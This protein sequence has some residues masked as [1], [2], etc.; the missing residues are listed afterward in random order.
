MNELVAKCFDVENPYFKKMIEIVKDNQQ[1]EKVVT[2]GRELHHFIPRAYYKKMNLSIDN[3]PENLVSLSPKDH[4]KIHYFIIFCCKPVIKNSMLY[5]FRNMYK[6]GRRG[7][8]E[9]ELDYFADAYERA[10][11][12]IIVSK[13]TRQ[14]LSIAKKGKKLS[15]ETRKKM[16]IAMTGKKHSEE[17]RKKIICVET[18]IVY[19]SLSEAAEKLNLNIGNL[20][21]CLHGRR[22][23]T[24][25]YHFH[26]A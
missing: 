17:A 8:T 15:E 9:K 24:G 22:K 14:K 3:S 26:L 18:G 7:M 16:S 11:S 10:K 5:A 20:S 12:M 23:T 4:F 21:A 1:H 25:G 2:T 13:A 6:M 19:S